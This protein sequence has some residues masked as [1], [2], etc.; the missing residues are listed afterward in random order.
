VLGIVSASRGDVMP[1]FQAILTNAVRICEAKFGLLA[2]QEGDSV[3]RPVA[4]H[5]LPA[6]YAQRVAERG[7]RPFRP[8]PMSSVG[9]VAATKRFVHVIDYRKELAY[10]EHDPVIVEAV[11]LG[12][13]RT[14]VT[15]P[16]LNEDTLTGAISIYRQ[17]VRPFTDRQIALV[18]NF[19]AQAVIAIENAR[20]LNELR[21]RT[22]DLA[23]ALEQQTAASEVLSIISSSPA[24][25]EPVFQAISKRHSAVRRQV[26]QSKP[27]R[28]RSIPKRSAL[29]CST[30]FRRCASA[31]SVAT[32]SSRRRCQGGADKAAG[33]D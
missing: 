14:L 32:P 29:Q 12:R 8:H 16:M 21:Q 3:F 17:E 11:E 18:Q 26:R 15:V 9:R 30:R 27:L 28:W 19:A 24:E 2:L 13:A 20:L 1:V 4:M 33:T 25:L 5:N 23:E 22:T 10:K 6:A 31:R 7:V